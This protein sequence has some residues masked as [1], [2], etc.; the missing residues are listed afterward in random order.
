MARSHKDQV[1]VTFRTSNEKLTSLCLVAFDSVASAKQHIA[2]DAAH[3]CKVHR[4]PM[5]KWIKPDSC[6]YFEVKFPRSGKRA[7][8]QYFGVPEVAKMKRS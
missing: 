6:D 7:V 2:E 1:L 3:Y 5:G 8:W 4:L